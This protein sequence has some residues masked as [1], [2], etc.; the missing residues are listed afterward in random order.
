MRRAGLLA[1]FLWVGCS[2]SYRAVFE[3]VEP[4]NGATA[5][6]PSLALKLEVAA[7]VSIHVVTREVVLYDVTGGARKTIPGTV[8]WEGRI[9]TYANVE[10]LVAEHEYELLAQS[11]IV[12]GEK[13]R[14]S[15][16]TEWPEEA[17]QWPYRLRFSTR[18]APRVRAAYLDLDS[19]PPRVFV[20][21]S[22]NMEQVGTSLQ[23]SLVDQLKKPVEFKGPIWVDAASARLDLVGPLD[24]ATLYT[25]QVGREAQ[26]ADGTRFDG[27]GNGVPGEADDQFAVQFTGAQ[28][29]ILSR[30][31]KQP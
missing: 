16:A 9:I 27:N 13:L 21:F 31:G 19:S 14:D 2:P 28:T 5:V 18:S 25:L 29:L 4:L 6:D 20:R 10:P 17:F 30:F 23:L 7:G 8:R 22:Q 3:R 24:A 11:S 1:V 15:D 26:A 12:S